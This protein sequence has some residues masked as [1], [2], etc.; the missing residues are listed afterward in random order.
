MCGSDSTSIRGPVCQ[1]M[2][3]SDKGRSGASASVRTDPPR[4]PPPPPAKVRRIL[5]DGVS[6]HSRPR[7]SLE[8]K[9]LGRHMV[10]SS[11]TPRGYGQV[12]DASAGADAVRAF[13]VGDFLGEDLYGVVCLG[14]PLSCC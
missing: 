6:E 4:P 3:T 13:F 12:V 1:V 9:R 11:Q 10:S 5:R 14:Q 8:S 2:E 7:G